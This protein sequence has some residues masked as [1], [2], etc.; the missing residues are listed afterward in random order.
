MCDEDYDEEDA[1]ELY[2]WLKQTLDIA[3]P[4]C[5]VHK[6]TRLRLVYITDDDGDLVTWYL[7]CPKPNCHREYM[8]TIE[9][10]LVDIPDD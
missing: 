10:T 9:F 6:K 8:L 5:R 7:E 4:C 1:P 2:L 3:E